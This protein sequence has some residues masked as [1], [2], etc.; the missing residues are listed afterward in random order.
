MLVAPKARVIDG[1]RIAS[2]AAN[3]ID[4]ECG[5]TKAN[6]DGD[7]KILAGGFQAIETMG[8]W[9]LSPGESISTLLYL[10]LGS[11]VYLNQNLREEDSPTFATATLG[12]T[13]MPVAAGTVG[14]ITVTDGAGAATWTSDA[15]HITLLAVGTALSF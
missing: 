8:Y 4:I 6:I 5:T 12:G 2:D 9:M 7:L 10:D 11:S 1:V 3:Q 15:E 13:V 14:Q